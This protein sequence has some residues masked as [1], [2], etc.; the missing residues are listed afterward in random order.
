LIAIA[1]E[2]WSRLQPNASSSGTIKTEGADLN[3]A[4]A[5]RV[6]KVTKAAIHA[7]CILL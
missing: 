3:P 5:T 7:G 2:I 6:K 1:R 4:V